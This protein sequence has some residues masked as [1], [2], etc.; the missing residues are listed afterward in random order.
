MRVF[1]WDKPFKDFAQYLRTRRNLVSI[2]PSRVLLL[3]ADLGVKTKM[4]FKVK[5]LDKLISKEN[6][7]EIRWHYIQVKWRG[8]E[9]PLKFLIVN[10]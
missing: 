1:H 9:K 3:L 7:K 5:I 2:N 8:V 4:L 10:P 6:Q